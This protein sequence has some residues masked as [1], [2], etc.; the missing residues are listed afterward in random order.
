MHIT[1][2]KRTAGFG[3]SVLKHLRSFAGVIIANLTLMHAN[4]PYIRDIKYNFITLHYVYLVLWAFVGSIVLVAGGNMP[5]ID[6]LFFASGAATQSGLNTID[7]NK[8]P[9]YAQIFLYVIG[10]WT[11]PIVVNTFVV[12][13]R[14]YWFEKRFQHIVRDARALRRTRTRTFTTGREQHDVNREEQGVRGQSIV[15]LRNEQGEARDG[16]QDS[17]KTDTDANSDTGTSNATSN[18]RRDESSKLSPPSPLSDTEGLRLP[19]QRSPEQHIAFLEH[20]RTDKGT[21]RIPSPREFDRGG[22]PQALDEAVEDNQD[23]PTS[24]QSRPVDEEQ[25]RQESGNELGNHI[26]INE[27]DIMR[28][29]ARTSTF[30]RINSQ[31]TTMRDEEGDNEPRRLRTRRGTFT[32]IFRSMTQ[33]QDRDTLPYLSWN[34]TV[35]R[36][37]AFIA[38]TEEQREELGGIEYRALK[39]LALVLVGYF[40]GFHI[41]GIVCLVPW[42]VA[43]QKYGA[44]VTGDGQGRAWWGVF[45]AQ[46]AFNDVGFTLTPDS[47][48]SF[49]E[50]VWPLLIMSFLIVIGNTGFPCML[51]LLIWIISKFT[52][53]G[54]ALWEELRFLLDHPRRCFTLLFPRN[55]TW[56]LFAILVVLNGADLLFFIIL[57]LNDPTITS[58]PAGYRVLD[59]LFQAFS[60]RTAGFGVVNLS[61]LHPAIQVSYLI[62]MYISVFPIAISMRRTNVYEER[63][64]GI[65]GSAEEEAEDVTEPSYI[66]AHLRRQLSFDLWYIFLGLFIIAIVE[67]D[68]LES[69]ADSYA[70]SLFAVLFEIVSAYGTVGLS[71]GYPNTNASFSGQFRVISK[72]VIIA[73]QIRGRHRGLPYALDRAILLPSESLQQR[74][75]DDAER[76]LR[77][78]TSNLS[79]MAANGQSSGIFQI[80]TNYSLGSRTRSRPRRS[81]DN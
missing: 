49:N 71:L 14:L 45:T 42:I 65:Y 75:Q 44:V 25:Q 52:I 24:P 17:H 57:D 81:E 47:M 13:V 30:P 27:P 61:A 3:A 74:E 48:N 58:I 63:S 35:G 66:G 54:S 76:R 40:V 1:H 15:V 7:I 79:D 60:T 36:N 78:R 64:L 12:F 11:N 50:A 6:A 46:S 2:V 80:G 34:A 69:G 16:T 22:V 23:N 26:T 31:R 68:R 62:M 9:T 18:D 53:T 41:M 19:T 38:L 33:E 55:A 28:F 20:Q 4:I 10:M 39:T 73:M 59:G 37:S 56:W 32:G 29:R 21:L 8:I 43:S 77:R 5:Y 51:R 70:F 67:A 72:L